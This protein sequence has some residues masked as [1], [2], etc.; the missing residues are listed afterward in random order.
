MNFGVKCPLGKELEN[1]HASSPDG[2]MVLV[3]ASNRK[4]LTQLTDFL[5]NLGPPSAT[6][7][8]NGIKQ[9]IASLTD[10][11]AQYF[12]FYRPEQS[13]QVRAPLLIGIVHTILDPKF[14]KTIQITESQFWK[15][16]RRSSTDNRA[17]AKK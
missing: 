10:G 5:V 8:R 4:S 12:V 6:V 3:C 13:L 17:N 14:P 7:R 1:S 9:I 15:T 2:T 11:P 16:D